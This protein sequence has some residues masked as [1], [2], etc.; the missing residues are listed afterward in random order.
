MGCFA[1]LRRRTSRSAAEGGSRRAA[2]AVAGR[3]RA[4]DVGAGGVPEYAARGERAARGTCDPG[5]PEGPR[6]IADQHDLPGDAGPVLVDLEL[7]LDPPVRWAELELGGAPAG[8]GAAGEHVAVLGQG[9]H[10]T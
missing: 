1:A 2:L 3:G 8:A 4:D 7:E 6:A 5:E 9:R 10:G